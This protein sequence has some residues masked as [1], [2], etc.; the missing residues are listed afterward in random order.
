MSLLHWA[1]LIK[2]RM[3]LLE[4]R[5]N[6]DGRNAQQLELRSRIKTANSFF[7]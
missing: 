4:G 7:L 5:E 3:V 6:T 2:N 1:V